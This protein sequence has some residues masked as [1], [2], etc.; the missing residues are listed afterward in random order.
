VLQ[1][2][3]WG[4]ALS[5]TAS[6]PWVGR[7]PAR[8]GGSFLQPWRDDLALP[9]TAWAERIARARLLG[10][11]HIVLQ[12]TRHGADYALTEAL[13]LDLLDLCHAAGCALTVGLPYDPRYWA[14]L[15]GK[16]AIGR[17]EFLAGVEQECAQWLATAP[18]A[19]HPAFRGWYV[20]YEL[21]Q[22]SW[23]TPEQIALLTDF[24]S[25]LMT[26]LA[27]SPV[28]IST[29]QSGVPG[30]GS[31]ARL[32][33]AI[34][35]KVTI[36]PMV[37]DG[38]GVFGMANYRHLEPLFASLRARGTAFDVVVEVFA[39]HANEHLAA[40]FTAEAA[41]AVRVQAQ[42]AA[43][44][45]TGADSLLAFALVP[46]MMSPAPHTTAAGAPGAAAL[47]RAYAAGL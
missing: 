4:A 37:Q 18:Y 25:R 27:P 19:A 32:W 29:F 6:T 16:T 22:Y 47:A 14:V 2:L 23:H 11:P 17:A 31:L 44:S 7:L 42:L 33:E 13:V 1:G 12:W 3:L 41:P 21:D 36:R 35:D 43:A 26:R 40:P 8:L 10:C 34:L 24:L 15:E 45:A 39:Q 5:L 30:P 38:V 28:A 46:Y 20:P 9:R